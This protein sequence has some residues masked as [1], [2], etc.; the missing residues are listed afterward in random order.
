MPKLIRDEV[1]AFLAEPGHLVRLATV[2]AD[3]APRVVPIW[4]VFEEDRIWMTPR[5]R[6]AWWSDLQGDQRV[7]LTVDEDA[8]PY[9]KVIHRGTCEI[10]H[11]PGEDDAWR[12][13]YRRIACRYV[14]EDAADAY[15][16]ATHDEPRALIA[17]DLDPATVTTWRMPVSGEDPT[18]IWARRYYHAR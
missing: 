8:A 6:S 5:E 9:R 12:D 4:F 2:D 14:P 18:G 10:V 16:T 11:R 3:G 13:R 17:L 1:E 15:L 7:A